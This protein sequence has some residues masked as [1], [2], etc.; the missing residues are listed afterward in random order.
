MRKRVITFGTVLAAFGAMLTLFVM[1]TITA[2][3]GWDPH[4]KPAAIRFNL[5][6]MVIAPTI[7]VGRAL[8]IEEGSHAFLWTSLAVALNGITCFALGA[9][10]GI[11]FSLATPTSISFH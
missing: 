10:L 4:G 11:F 5:S 3:F 2:D 8:G 7:A 6:M 1:T 9:V